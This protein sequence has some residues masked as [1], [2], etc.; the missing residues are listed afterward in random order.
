MTAILYANGDSFV[1]GM[2]CIG[3]YN[4]EESN[5]E[6]SFPK[7]I[8]T[9]LGCSTYINNA[10]NGATNEF[11]FRT[12]LFDLLELEK[13]GVDSKDVFVLIGWT[14][15]HRTE[16]DGKGFYDKIPNYRHNEAYLLTSPNASIEY[17]DYKTLF[18]NPTAGHF[19]EFDGKVYDTKDEILPFCVNYLWSDHLQLPQTE[20]NILA[21]H[22]YLES[23]GYRHLFV[24]T[25]EPYKFDK[26]PDKK[27]FYDLKNESFYN[28]ALKHYKKNQREANHFD[29][30]P[31]T[32]YG[33]LLVDYIS[34]N[35]V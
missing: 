21:L 34:R 28:W 8:S 25:V 9:S 17:R 7:H 24:N 30:V 35:N 12:T 10:Y 16:V 33:K 29:P 6:F 5:K 27:N 1:F 32:V 13:T 20:A 22:T 15:I 19:V 14:S 31:H 4:K 26:L 11:I 18:I 3:D 2:E 23:K